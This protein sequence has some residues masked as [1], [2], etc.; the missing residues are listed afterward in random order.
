MPRVRLA[1]FFKI[2]IP[3]L[4]EIFRTAIKGLL[5]EFLIDH[6]LIFN[7]IIFNG[8]SLSCLFHSYQ[9]SLVAYLIFHFECEEPNF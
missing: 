7:E 3:L 6:V 9:F 1:E 8:L 2:D 4:A 5:F